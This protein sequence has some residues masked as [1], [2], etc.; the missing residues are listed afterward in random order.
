M[1]GKL[2]AC[3]AILRRIIPAPQ[4]KL[5]GIADN[6]APVEPKPSTATRLTTSAKVVASKL[7]EIKLP[8][9]FS[10]D[11]PDF[12]Q[13]KAARLI[14]EQEKDKLRI[15]QRKCMAAGIAK[16]EELERE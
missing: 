1:A 16:M 12:A 15:A 8:A 6:I 3:R 9:E 2:S 11:D 10:E 5:L 14:A 13:F 7:P 4:A